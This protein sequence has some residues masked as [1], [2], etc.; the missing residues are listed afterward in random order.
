ME[1]NGMRER[2]G[3]A[4]FLWSSATDCMTKE[5]VLIP[6]QLVYASNMFRHETQLAAESITTGAA[7]GSDSEYV[8]ENG[9]LEVVE[10]D[11]FIIAYLTKR[12][13]KRIVQVPTSIRDLIGYLK[14][15]YLDVFI[16]DITTDLHIPSFMTIIVDKRGFGPAISVGLKAGFDIE[17]AVFGSILEAVQPRRQF[18]YNKEMEGDKFRFPKASDIISPST[19]YFYWYQ[20]KMIG[21]LDFWLKSKNTI[22][23]GQMPKYASSLK[24]GLKRLRALK[25]H[26]FYADVTLDEIRKA[27]FV[28]GKVLIPELHPV[29][30][31]EYA[32]VLYSVHVGNIEP[33]RGLE[34]HPF[35]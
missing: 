29:Y 22:K 1:L 2:L 27:G 10:R 18:R 7:L 34:P 23:F 3:A 30:L 25:Y 4:T 32:K 5:K 28:V 31:S 33:I 21:H 17:K 8:F 14:R 24:D 35:A 9:L 12:K 11:S 19:R 15:Y 26:I 13:L 20:T 16:Y 6:A